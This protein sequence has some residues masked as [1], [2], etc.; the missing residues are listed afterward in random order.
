MF[1]WVYICGILC[2]PVVIFHFT[3]HKLKTEEHAA[4]GNHNSTYMV[5]PCIILH[6]LRLM[7][8]I[9]YIESQNVLQNVS[10]EQ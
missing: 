10:L 5:I 1:L 9:K 2:W 4:V 8:T 3:G 6:V 7:A